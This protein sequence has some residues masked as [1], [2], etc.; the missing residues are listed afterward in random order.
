MQECMYND[1]RNHSLFNQCFKQNIDVFLPALP[2]K[3][4]KQAL[5]VYG[6]CVINLQKQSR[7]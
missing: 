1:A 2:I 7:R 3:T 5:S 4:C 6:L